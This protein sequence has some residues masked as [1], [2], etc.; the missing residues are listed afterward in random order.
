MCQSPSDA[1]DSRVLPAGSPA[2]R[3]AA[4][5]LPSRSWLQWV[6]T[7]DLLTGCY[8][9]Q[10]L[11]WE[12]WGPGAYELDVR[13]G[14]DGRASEGEVAGGPAPEGPES[15]ADPYRAASPEAV[16]APGSAVDQVARGVNDI[17]A[18]REMG[19]QQ[20]VERLGSRKLARRFELPELSWSPPS[21]TSASTT[22]RRGPG[23]RDDSRPRPG[24]H[25]A[26]SRGGRRPRT[27]GRRLAALLL[28]STGANNR[29]PIAPSAG[30]THLPAP[31]IG[32][33]EVLGPPL[34]A[35][36]AV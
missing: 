25:G 34:S 29:R 4:A 32:H 5:L 1:E 17:A 13:D 26:L 36:S 14:R 30:Q 31:R 12:K 35:L 18:L 15:E 2:E 20:V 19:D 16:Q 24:P 33:V 9:E 6:S 8:A 28:R 21:T 23:R 22:G 7:Q 27:S 11:P 3:V 10:A